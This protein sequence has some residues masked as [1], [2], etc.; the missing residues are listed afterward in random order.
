MIDY[1]CFN[2]TECGRKTELSKFKENQ[3]MPCEG[4]SDFETPPISDSRFLAKSP[5]KENNQ[6]LSNVLETYSTSLKC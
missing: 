3:P 2:L 1:P 5:Q 4:I 6:R